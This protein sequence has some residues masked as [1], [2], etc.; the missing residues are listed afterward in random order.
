MAT[1]FITSSANK[2]AHALRRAYPQLTWGEAF[3]L[4][5][6]S[7]SAGER[8]VRR[9]DSVFGVWRKQTQEKVGEQ[10]LAIGAAYSLL[11]DGRAHTFTNFGKV[12]ASAT[13]RGVMG[14][15]ADMLALKGVGESVISEV[16]EMFVQSRREGLS[17][18]ER[19]TARV[20]ALRAALYEKFLSAK[21]AREA[22]NIA[23]VAYAMKAIH[24]WCCADELDNA[25]ALPF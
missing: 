21:S 22:E 8:D 6:A 14:G 25:D 2:I 11:G 5:I 13:R 7:E 16:V 15:F 19:L 24:W 20:R 23:D 1:N 9:V 17:E 3:R 18:E 10:M 4:A 12:L